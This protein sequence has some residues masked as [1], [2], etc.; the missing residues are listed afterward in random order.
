MPLIK[1]TFVN[2]IHQKA[3]PFFAADSIVVES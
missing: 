2:L 3:S 1:A